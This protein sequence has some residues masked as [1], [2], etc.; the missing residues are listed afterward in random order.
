MISINTS[1]FIY[2]KLKLYKNATRTKIKLYTNVINIFFSINI[3]KISLGRGV[4]L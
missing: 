2:I 1:R 4:R 3:K